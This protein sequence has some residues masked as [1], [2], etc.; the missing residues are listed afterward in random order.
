MTVVGRKTKAGVSYARFGCTAHASHGASICANALSI[1]EKK[2]SRTLVNALRD[3]LARPELVERFVAAF[4]QRTAGR[5]TE[6][7]GPVASERRVRDC[8][9]RV[10]NLT[11]ALARVRIGHG[12]RTETPLTVLS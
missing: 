9:R 11:E 1:S 3:K 2:A 6:G 7:S 8:E 12:W 5:L 4:K 10:A